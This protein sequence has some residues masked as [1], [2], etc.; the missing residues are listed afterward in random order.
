MLALPAGF[1]FHLGNAWEEQAASGT[2]IHVDYVRA[3]D[4]SSLFT[5]T[6]ELMRGRYAGGPHARLTV[7]RLDLGAGRATQVEWPLE[8]EFPRIDPRRVG[9][10]HRQVIHAAEPIDG[11]PLWSAVARTD[12]ESGASQRFRYGRH[13][14]VEEHVFV[15]DGERAGWVLGTALDYAQG[16]TVLSCFAADALA[17]G[18]VA[19][20]TLPYALPLGL[21]G[22]FVAA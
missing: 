1:L 17:D 5:S 14:L 18:P 4:A 2:V 8:A 7:A 22:A 10:R 11:R 9:L 20:A 19:Q 12:V 21:H 16:R 6:R 15:P 3:P 13:A